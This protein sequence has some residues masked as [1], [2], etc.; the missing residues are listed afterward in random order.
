MGDR[1]NV[2]SRRLRRRTLV[3]EPPPKRCL[4]R[5]HP[6]PDFDGFRLLESFRSLGLHR[7]CLGRGDTQPRFTSQRGT[8]GGATA[9]PPPPPS[10]PGVSRL[11]GRREQNN[12]QG[13]DHPPPQHH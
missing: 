8:G 9:T 1:H 10:I 11:T 12:D 6:I 4:L 7:L 5:E 13:P 3:G 2:A